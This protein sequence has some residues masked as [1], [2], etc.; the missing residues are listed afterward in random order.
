MKKSILETLKNNKI[1][2]FLF[3][4][5]L[6]IRL[7]FINE[8]MPFITHPDEPTVVNST[9]NLRYDLNP[10]HF[11]WPTFYY[12]INYLFFSIIFLVERI[13]NKLGFANSSIV[14]TENFYLMSRIVTS[15]FGALSVVFM[16]LFVHKLT[17]K[18]DI[19][20]ISAI[21]LS[22]L[23]FHI[24]R[25]AQSLTDVPM[26]F[27]I[28]CSLYYLSKNIDEFSWKNIYISSLFVGFAVSTKYNAY[29]ISLSLILFIFLIKK[30]SIKDFLNYVYASFFAFLGFLIGT[31]YAL[32][33][34]KTFIRDDGPKGALW[35]FKN[36]GSIGIFEQIPAFFNNIGISLLPDFAFIP[37]ILTLVF[38]AYFI[39]QNIFLVEKGKLFKDSYS[40]FILILIIQFIFIMWSVSGVKIQR[41]HYFMA[42]YSIVPVFVAILI[43]KNQRILYGSLITTFVLSLVL[44]VSNISSNSRIEFFE[45]V[46]FKNEKKNYN[47][48]Y[49]DSEL[50]EVFKKLDIKSDEFDPGMLDFNSKYYTHLISSQN[51]C[52]G[53]GECNYKLIERITNKEKGNDLFIYEIKK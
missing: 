9:L 8:D 48:L 51:L 31:P 40:K 16:Y 20:L 43:S 46:D 5:S 37:W 12:Y 33:D 4:F 13:S 39:Y 10:K 2:I 29:M 42:V 22:V 52:T 15:F 25:S 32:L 21:V 3:I 24:T 19:S 11:D 6:F 53:S 50:K 34:F 7:I 35:Q 47:I 49:S 23:P 45:R 18:S 28:I 36:V 17:K 26:L 44:L 38:I 27:F 41:S 1:L 14:A 30:F